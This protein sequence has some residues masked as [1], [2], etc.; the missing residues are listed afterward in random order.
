LLELRQ[1]GDV[2]AHVTR[3]HVTRARVTHR[4]RKRAYY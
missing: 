3:A 1:H 4:A 2:T